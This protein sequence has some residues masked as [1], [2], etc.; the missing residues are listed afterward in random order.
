[1]MLVINVTAMSINGISTNEDKMETMVA[2][3]NELRLFTFMLIR[4]VM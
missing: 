3:S 2:A 4:N 1:M